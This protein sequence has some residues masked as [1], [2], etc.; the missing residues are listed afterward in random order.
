[1]KG[2]KWATHTIDM[3][4]FSLKKLNEVEG[5]EEYLI[6][7]IKEVCSFTKLK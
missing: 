2:K 4:G 7:M 6:K 5:K 3:E 1:V